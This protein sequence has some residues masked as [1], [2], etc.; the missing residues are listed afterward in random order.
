MKGGHFAEGPE[1]TAECTI[2]DQS[3]FLDII[4]H[5]GK[6]F[7]SKET[8]EMILKQAFDYTGHYKNMDKKTLTRQQL[9]EIEE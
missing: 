8:A 9:Q 1:V 7:Y 4:R 3:G 6:H 5:K 2:V